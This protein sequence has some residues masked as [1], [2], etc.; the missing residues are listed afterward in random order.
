MQTL[1]IWT[2]RCQKLFMSNARHAT[3]RFCFNFELFFIQEFRGISIRP[4][5]ASLAQALSTK[6]TKTAQNIFHYSFSF[7]FNYYVRVYARKLRNAF[8][9][10]IYLPVIYYE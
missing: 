2:F 7:C 5:L 9:L 10:N 6:K 1:F 4:C 8:K 3:K